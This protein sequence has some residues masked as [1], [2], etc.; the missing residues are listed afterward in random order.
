MHCKNLQPDGHRG[1]ADKDDNKIRNNKQQNEVMPV[2]GE[3]GEG[4]GGR[5]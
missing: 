3:G 2:Y 4:G 1:A 5:R